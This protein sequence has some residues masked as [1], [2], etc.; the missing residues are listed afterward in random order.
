[1]KPETQPDTSTQI[2]IVEDSLGVS[3][4]LQRALSLH[5]DGIYR[6]ET[7][8]RATTALERLMEQRFDLLITDLR[9]PGIDGLE[10]L[11]RANTLHP[12]MPTMLI[13]AYS[14]P[15]V[16]TRARTLA[17]TYLPKPF[18]LRDIIR[19]VEKILQEPKPRAKTRERTTLQTLSAADVEVDIS[20]RKSTHLIVLASDLD[21]TLA[22]EGAVSVETWNALRRA[23][24][25]GLTLI[26]VT[27]R[28]LDDFVAKGPFAELCEAIVAENG[29]VVYFPRRDL[30]DLPFGRLNPQAL[31]RLETMSVPLERGMAIAATVLPY[32]EAVL[33]ALRESK[34]SA[35][36]EYNRNAVMALPAGATK[37]SGLLHALRAQGYSPRN[38]VACG[39]AENDRSLFEAVELAVAVS[40]AQPALKAEADVVLSEPSGKGVQALIER[41]LQGQVPERTPRPHRR[42]LLGH[43]MSGT[44]VHLDPFALVENNVGIFGASASGKS[45]L[46]GLLAEELLKQGYQVCIID[47]EG[48]YRGLGTASHTLLLGGPDTP[49]PPIGDIINFSEWTTTSLILELSAY[50][51]EARITYMQEFMRALQSLR[52]RRGRPHC[53]LV[54][55]IQSF[56]PPGDGAPV[57]TQQFLTAMQ[58]GGFC[59]I[60]FRPSQIA[61]E[62]RAMLD[63]VIV[64]P[65]NL[66]EEIEILSP[67]LGQYA[68]GAEVLAQLPTLPKGQAYLCPSLSQPWMNGFGDVVKFRV[69]PRNIPHVRHLHKYLRVPLPEA[70]RFYFHNAGSYYLGESA[71]NLWE[72]REALNEIPIDSLEYHMERND[73]EHWLGSALQ[74]AELARRVR[75]LAGHHLEGEVLRRA[76]LNIVIDRYEELEA[77]I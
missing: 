41:L 42:L 12:E 74:D 53:F 25:A 50:T 73:F 17:D 70:K 61:P 44:P 13:T 69:G 27:G 2:L 64:T 43:R 66:P 65:L 31:Q 9:M 29:A 5:Q 14:T 40:N 3:R 15:E 22:E 20:A 4:A 37:G 24:I 16:E 75:K 59:V 62:I 54:D 8:E 46:A 56:C 52:S 45:W 18:S 51:W 48:D 28:T 6:V 68:S 49:L 57:L 21:G 10:L 30:V 67:R 19:R 71:A 1:M 39:D 35:T 63:H 58:W 47:P 11:E 26:L 36:V 34:S 32:D 76:L 33:R 60:S 77:L 23:R 7:C 38:V 55:E 72:F